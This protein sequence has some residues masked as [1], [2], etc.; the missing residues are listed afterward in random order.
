MFSIHYTDFDIRFIIVE[1]LAKQG[2]GGGALF[3]HCK[4]SQMFVDSSNLRTI[5]P[6]SPRQGSSSCTR[7]SAS[8][9]GD[10]STVAAWKLGSEPA[11]L[12]KKNTTTVSSAGGRRRIRAG[13]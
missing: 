9:P 5:S 4:T 6:A 7:V 1:A 2:E 3:R 13:D 11:E 8:W 10:S 12:R